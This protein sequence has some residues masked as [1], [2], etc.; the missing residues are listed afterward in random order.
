MIDELAAADYELE[1]DQIKEQLLKEEAMLK[2][3]CYA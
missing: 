2:V 1:T 3:W